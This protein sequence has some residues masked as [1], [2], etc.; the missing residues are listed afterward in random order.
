MTF[1]VRLIVVSLLTVL[2]PMGIL[3]LVVRNE[4]TQRLTTQYERRVDALVS[5][6]EED[7]SRETRMIAAALRTVRQAVLEDNR[8]R[9]SVVAEA[10][11]ERRYRLD[12]A[13]GAMRLAGLSMLQIQD[14]QGRILSSGHFRNEYDR[15]EPGL[16]VLLSGVSEGWALVKARSP[17]APFVVLARADSLAMGGRRLT[18][19]GGIR[20]GDRLLSR[21]GGALGESGIAIALEYP[22]SDQDAPDPGLRGRDP[23][24]PGSSGARRYITRELNVPFVDGARQAV[25]TAR[26]RV[27]HGLEELD[28]LR[29]GVDRWFIV[30][31]ALTAFLAVVISVWVSSRISRPLSELVQKTAG[32]DLDRFDIDFGTERR[33]EI[34]VLARTLEE[35]TGRLRASAAQIKEA[36]R[37]ATLGEVA[38]QVNHDIKNGLTPIRNVFRHLKQVASNRPSELADV[39]NERQ[40][41]VES[42]MMYLEALASNYARLSPRSHR[43]SCDVSMLVRRIVANLQGLP[44][45]EFDLRLARDATVIADAVALRRIVENLVDNAIDSLGSHPGRV[46]I[47][48]ERVVQDDGAQRVHF[49]VTDTGK[50]MSD[51]VRRRVFDDFFTTKHD[52]MG[53]GLSIVRRLVTDLDGTIHV[54]S[55]E[56]KGSRFRIDLPASGS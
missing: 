17:D 43:S 38:R 54:D 49:A 19:V 3:A 55:E 8:F 45:V 22:G 11:E 44:G 16:P 30:A 20:V 5:V 15:L 34:G 31:V 48:T 14:E 35:M 33:D 2:L 29:A 26:F 23:A 27:T 50:G 46:T 40:Q 52:G 51:E 42:S 12:F 53:L 9:R 47:T 32:V 4:M 41:T 10:P 37:R 13:E 24:M 18:L 1:R 25:S 56:G 7:L 6:I 36:E 39:F 21:L 28:A